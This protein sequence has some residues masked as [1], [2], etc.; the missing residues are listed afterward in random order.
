MT[1]SNLEQARHEMNS[2]MNTEDNQMGFVKLEHAME[3]VLELASQNI[4]SEVVAKAEGLEE[5]RKEQVDSIKTI[6]DFF[7]NYWIREDN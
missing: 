2:D 1:S 3:I 7:T 5:Y 4:I 6:E